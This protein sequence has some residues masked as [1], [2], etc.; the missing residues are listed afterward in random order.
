VVAFV[1]AVAIPLAFL[2]GFTVFALRQ[3]RKLAS[4]PP[5]W[6]P[7]PPPKWL[8]AV[9]LA[10]YGVDFGWQLS[11]HRYFNAAIPVIYIVFLVAMALVRRDQ[12]KSV[13]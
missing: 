5:G 10:L 4:R 2:V 12:K 11:D 8:L 3:G 7:R 13:S 6:R 9:G 1:L